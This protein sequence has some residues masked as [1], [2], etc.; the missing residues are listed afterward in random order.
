MEW[1]TKNCYS[2]HYTE[3]DFDYRYD[4]HPHP[5]APEKH[6]HP[7][8]DASDAVPSCIEVETADLVTMA[9]LQLWRDALASG[10]LSRLQQSGPP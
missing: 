2:L 1:T 8:P 7:P 4:R 3:G 5:D 9:V 10:D 6:F